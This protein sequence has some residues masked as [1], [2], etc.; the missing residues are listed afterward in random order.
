M[1]YPMYFFV[2]AL[3]IAV[4][5]LSSP[6]QALCRGRVRKARWRRLDPMRNPF[7]YDRDSV[8]EQ[9]TEYGFGRGRFP[10]PNIDFSEVGVKS[11]IP[12]ADPDR[13]EQLRDLA[14][15]RRM[16]VNDPAAQPDPYVCGN[17]DRYGAQPPL[18][19]ERRAPTTPRPKYTQRPR[20]ERQW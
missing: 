11:R 19:R 8:S 20:M 17:T 14:A 4:K 1:N 2:A 13:T 10:D 12:I 9:D 15:I 18:V 7:G 5:M 16:D 3:L 6:C